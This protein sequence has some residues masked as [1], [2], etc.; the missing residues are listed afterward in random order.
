MPALIEKK[1]T[2]RGIE[3]RTVWLKASCSAAELVG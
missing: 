3:P 1:V 2:H